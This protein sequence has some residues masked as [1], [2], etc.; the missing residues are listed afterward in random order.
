M[1]TIRPVQPSDV[2]KITDLYNWYIV[3]T[4]ITFE[5]AAIAY[6]EM[7]KRIQERVQQ[8]DWLVAEINQEVVGYAYY[9]KFHT[10]AA[11][12]HTVESSIYLSSE[13]TGK[14]LG[15]ALYSALIQSATTHGFRELISLVT[16]PNPAS[17]TLHQ[18]L[19]FIEAGLLR[20]VGYKFDQYLDVSIWQK[21]LL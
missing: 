19:G 7:E 21:S 16:L 5:I 14:G 12:R 9:G 3:N 10:R 4:T 20:N 15:T 6:A 17:L 18:K 11:Y 1:I 8:Y 13:H 2:V